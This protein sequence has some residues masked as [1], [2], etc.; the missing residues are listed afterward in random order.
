VQVV[1]RDAKANYDISREI[2]GRIA[3]STDDAHA[4]YSVVGDLKAANLQG[5]VV[6]CGSG[7]PHA[8]ATI[9][10]ANVRDARQLDA[11]EQANAR[12]A[13]QLDQLALGNLRLKAAVDGYARTFA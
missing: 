11:L 12:D 2:E 8:L 4:L 1:G 10:A 6:D 13:K 9:A 7:S 3:L 5:D